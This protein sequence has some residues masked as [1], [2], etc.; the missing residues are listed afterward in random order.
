MMELQNMPMREEDVPDE[1]ALG[2]ADL[3]TFTLHELRTY[4]QEFGNIIG[5]GGFGTVY[6]GMISGRNDDLNGKRI[7]VKASKGIAGEFRNEW[8]AEIRYLSTLNHPNIIKLIGK[9]ATTMRLFLVYPFVN[10][11]SVH[12]KLSGL[13]WRRS[14]GIMRGAAR[15]L[16]H[17]HSQSP[18][19]IFRDFKSEN[20]L[21]DENWN[22]IVCDFGTVR[23]EGEVGFAG[24]IGYTEPIVLLSDG[25]DDGFKSSNDP[26][27]L[28]SKI[29]SRS[30]QT[31]R[32][33]ITASAKEG[34]PVTCLVYTLL[35][36]WATEVDHNLHIPSVLTWKQPATVLDI[37]YFYFN[38]YGEMVVVF[39]EAQINLF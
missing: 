34:H 5:A 13:N 2:S 27:Y 29:R 18:P 31:L 36:P 15:A 23:P 16:Q 35:H 10:K 21:L 14:L 4:T 3:V 25:Y 17:L 22:P 6:E 30:S 37:Y 24:T 20:I 39:L 8:E 26:Q 11:G 32:E 38:G 1:L 28:V 12:S 19:L 9:C 7:A 33:I